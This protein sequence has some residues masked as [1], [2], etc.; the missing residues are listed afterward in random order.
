MRWDQRHSAG[1]ETAAARLG[2]PVPLDVRSLDVI[3]ARA[4]GVGR[5]GAP[6][7]TVEP[8]APAD[9]REAA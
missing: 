4:L 2:A 7:V 5:D 1:W 6:L 8:N 3:T 9:V